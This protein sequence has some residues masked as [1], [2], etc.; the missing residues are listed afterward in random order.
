M[1]IGKDMHREKYWKEVRVA[2]GCFKDEWAKISL[3]FP[4]RIW[5][6]YQK[7][8][9]EK[10]ACRSVVAGNDMSG[11][12]LPIGRLGL[13]G[14]KSKAERIFTLGKSSTNLW[15]KTRNP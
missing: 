13:E 7:G 14:V 11:C 1:D 15:I 10:D 5:N 9:E 8:G 12:R 2:G 3:S 6:E 4:N